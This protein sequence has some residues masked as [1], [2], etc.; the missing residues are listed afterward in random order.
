MQENQWP[1]NPALTF[2]QSKRIC[3]DHAARGPE[4][5]DTERALLA[6]IKEKAVFIDPTLDPYFEKFG[7]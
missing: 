7:V 2:W 5:H 1:R 4:P 6:Y 3:S